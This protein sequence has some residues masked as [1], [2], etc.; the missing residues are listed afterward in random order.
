[1]RSAGAF[2]HVVT[3]TPKLPPTQSSA[4]TQGQNLMTKREEKSVVKQ[5]PFSKSLSS[6]GKLVAFPHL[7]EREGSK[8]NVWPA[9]YQQ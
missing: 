8:Y 5:H 7:Y 2:L 6:L 9:T 3:W 4:M 1:M